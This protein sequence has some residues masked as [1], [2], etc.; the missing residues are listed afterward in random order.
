MNEDTVARKA[1]NVSVRADLLAEA[2]AAK[3]NLSRTLDAALRLELK[4]QRE[5]RWR[6]ENAEAIAA[7]NAHVE[8]HGL[9]CDETRDA[10]WSGLAKP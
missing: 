9:W 10:I 3:L 1:V 6:A 5:A 8:K 2:R 4:A 7:Y